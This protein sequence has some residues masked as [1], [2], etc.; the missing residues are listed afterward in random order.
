MSKEIVKNHKMI[1]HVDPKT[2]EHI[3]QDEWVTTKKQKLNKEKGFNLVYIF[4]LKDVLLEFDSAKAIYC[5][6]DILSEIVKTDFTL[7]LTYKDIMKIYNYEEAQAKRIM[8][9][10]K[11]TGVIKGSRGIYDV[12]P[13]LVI[14]KN[15]NDS[16]VTKKQNSWHSI[17]S[18]GTVIP[19]V[20]IYEANE[21]PSDPL[22]DEIDEYEDEE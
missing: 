22:N 21:S 20:S 4:Y 6:L 11:K 8:A 9:K 17:N 15:S 18:N 13:F 5:V 10:L 2:G 14:P 12:N 19:K 16:L 7:E 3:I 1:T